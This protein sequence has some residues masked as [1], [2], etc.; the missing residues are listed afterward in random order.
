MKNELLIGGITLVSALSSH[1]AAIAFTEM[2]AREGNVS[3][4]TLGAI[5]EPADQAAITALT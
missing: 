2:D 1:A 3:V 5:T 4:G